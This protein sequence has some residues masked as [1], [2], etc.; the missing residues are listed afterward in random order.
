MAERESLLEVDPVHAVDDPRVADVVARPRPDVI[1]GLAG[2]ERN[3]PLAISPSA[4]RVARPV[5]DGHGDPIGGLIVEYAISVLHNGGYAAHPRY[6]TARRRQSE[7]NQIPMR[8][9]VA[10]VVDRLG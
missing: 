1:T 6:G 10:I 5:C 9:A 4:D 7:S 3:L 8:D 2:G